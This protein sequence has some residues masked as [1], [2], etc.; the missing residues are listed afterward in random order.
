MEREW[1][2]ETFRARPRTGNGSAEGEGFHGE[3][4]MKE[5][6]SEFMDEGKRFLRSEITLAKSDLRAEMQKVQKGGIS[7]GIGAGLAVAGG[8]ILCAF[9]VLALATFMPAWLSA[10][11]VGAVFVGIGAAVAMAGVK[12]IKTADP[13]KSMDR[14]QEDRQWLMSTAQE[15]KTARH[16]SVRQR[17]HASA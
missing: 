2:E 7:V 17:P 11:I 10:L 9:L 5:L 14:I 4:S 3:S 15:A 8:L 12:R 6:I 16:S 1:K 13:K